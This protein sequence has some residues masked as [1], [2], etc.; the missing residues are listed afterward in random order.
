MLTSCGIVRG[1]DSVSSPSNA[2]DTELID[3]LTY[4]SIAATRQSLC[5][6]WIA[7]NGAGAP[8]FEFLQ[9]SGFTEL[10]DFTATT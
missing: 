2:S 6:A 4:S 8:G 9:P 5:L 10:V 1:A 7:R 3:T